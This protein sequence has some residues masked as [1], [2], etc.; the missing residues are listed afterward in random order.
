MHTWTVTSLDHPP[1]QRYAPASKTRPLRGHK[2]KPQPV[3]HSLTHHAGI[4]QQ[5]HRALAGISNTDLGSIADAVLGKPRR[6]CTAAFAFGMSHTQ[7]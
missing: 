2:P 6:D 7:A 5:Q 1:P 4:T 3:F